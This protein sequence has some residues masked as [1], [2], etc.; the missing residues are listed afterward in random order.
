MRG[1]SSLFFSPPPLTPASPSLPRSKVISS[2][3]DDAPLA[4]LAIKQL[5]LYLAAPG[6]PDGR[7]SRS[8]SVAK[9]DA[10]LASLTDSSVPGGHTLQAVVGTL[11]IHEE[12]YDAALKAVRSGAS[13]ELLS[14]AVQILLRLDRADLA[15]RQLKLMQE[16]DDESALTQLSAAAVGLAVGGPRG[17]EAG[18]L[19]RDMLER[20]GETV[21]VLNGAAVAALAGR[22]YAEAAKFAGD[23][24]AREPSNP[25]SLANMLCVV[26]HTGRGAETAALLERLRA[27][28]PGHPYL[29]AFTIAE[30]S[31]DRVAASFAP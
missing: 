14:L 6:G 30:S 19:Y 27:C 2:I 5:A 22:S 23:A 25:E 20:Y 12:R 15:D 8:A 1:A 21:P 29:T 11:L 31:F 3:K 9:V 4:L 16:R 10:L 17:R 18:L 26:Q 13:L 28:A 7:S 24:L